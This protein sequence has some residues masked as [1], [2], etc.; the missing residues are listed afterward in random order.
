LFLAPPCKRITP[1]IA[2]QEKESF[3]AAKRPHKGKKSSCNGSFAAEKS[4]TK[5]C[6]RKQLRRTIL[7]KEVAKTSRFL[8]RTFSATNIANVGAFA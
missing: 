1:N 7:K 4:H 5:K 3:A 2:L 8:R 6:G